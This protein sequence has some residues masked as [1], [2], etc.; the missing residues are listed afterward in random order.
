LIF[1]Q[2][3]LIIGHKYTTQVIIG[4][5]VLPREA[6]RPHHR[7]ARSLNSSFPSMALPQ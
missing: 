6:G 3:Q 7:V 2:E 5:N 4:E 1:E